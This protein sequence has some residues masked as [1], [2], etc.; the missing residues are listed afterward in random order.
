MVKKKSTPN[1]TDD[2][3]RLAVFNLYCDGKN[4]S[5]A[6]RIVGVSEKTAHNWKKQKW[7]EDW[8]KAR[9]KR[10]ELRKKALEDESLEKISSMHRRQQKRFQSVL[11]IT[12]NAIATKMRAGTFDD[13]VAAD[14]LFRGSDAERRLY[15]EPEIAYA[16]P[17]QGG[18]L[19]VG[20][21]AFT[22]ANG[23]VG[24][25]AVMNQMWEERN[26]NPGK[27]V[28]EATSQPN[29]SGDKEHT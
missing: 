9:E 17:K 19:Q 29:D 4:I 23:E 16:P 11:D 18:N 25:L 1:K 12:A 28:I 14:I 7:P 5:E 21:S 15:I 24:V 13:E 22:K 10:V 8:P 27:R 3:I 20:A 6:C 2:D 26:G